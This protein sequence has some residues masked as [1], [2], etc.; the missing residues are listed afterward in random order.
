MKCGYVGCKSEATLSL[1]LK[2]GKKQK[3]PVCDKHAPDW[4]KDGTQPKF[5]DVVK[6]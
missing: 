5:Y 3:L 4:A 1:N 2:I 6:I